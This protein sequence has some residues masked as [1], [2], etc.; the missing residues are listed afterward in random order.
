[1][2]RVST[3]TGFSPLEFVV[4]EDLDRVWLR[5]VREFG[6]PTTISRG[7]YT[8][9]GHADTSGRAA[10]SSRILYPDNGCVSAQLCL[11]P[12]EGAISEPIVSFFYTFVNLE[13]Q[14]NR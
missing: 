11:Q 1:M 13:K 12:G 9:D 2:V 3:A 7:G 14:K 4:D 10:A 6:F 5:V 8:T